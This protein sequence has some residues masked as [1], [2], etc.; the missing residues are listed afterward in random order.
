MC[1]PPNPSAISAFPHPAGQQE[2]RRPQHH[3]AQPHHRHDAHR[4]RPRRHDP[5]PRRAAATSPAAAPQSPAPNS[6]AVSTAP[7]TSGGARLSAIFRPGPESSG[8]RAARA[9]RTTAHPPIASASTASALHTPSHAASVRLPRRQPRR[10]QRRQ[11]HRHLAPPR[12]RREAPR[13]LHR[14][15]DEAQVVHRPVVQRHGS[16][17]REREGC[18]LPWAGRIAGDG[19]SVKY[20]TSQSRC[21]GRRAASP[22]PSSRRRR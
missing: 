19:A 9:F 2:R 6:T 3:E 13:P 10:Q 20:F 21:R 16:A 4:V 18:S 15:A 11:P 8:I 14:L 5:A 1:S 12:D 17:R 7:A 22:G